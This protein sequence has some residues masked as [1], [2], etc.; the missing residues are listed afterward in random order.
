VFFLIWGRG[1]EVVPIRDAG[2]RICR[3][4]REDRRVGLLLRYD[5][6]HFFFVFGLVT[7]KRFLLAC[8]QCGNSWVI[9]TVEVP[10]A[11]AVAR[12]AVP[13]LRRWG[14]LLFLLVGGLISSTVIYL[15][16][17]GVEERFQRRQKE[18]NAPLIRIDKPVPVRKPEEIPPVTKATQALD[19]RPSSPTN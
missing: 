10:D 13:F 18:Q 16:F 6:A 17:E 14:L 1:R 7:R 12:K 15:F 3:V 4:C 9:P 5:Y 8:Q 11:K 2:T 19:E